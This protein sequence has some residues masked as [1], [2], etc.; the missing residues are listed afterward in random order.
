MDIKLYFNVLRQIFPHRSPSTTRLPLC[1]LLLPVNCVELTVM[2]MKKW[3]TLRM[4]VFWDV[5]MC[6]L[7]EVWRRL[8]GACCL[9]RIVKVITHHPDGGS[10]VHLIIVG[11][12]LPDRPLQHTRRQ[13][14]SYSPSW[15]PKRSSGTHF[16][17]A[18]NRKCV[19]LENSEN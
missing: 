7:V 3:C 1:C 10:S 17:T 2:D 9:Y 8:W 12:R 16:S 14:S 18:L 5:A 6:S 19:G 4:T 13:P 11:K 15:E